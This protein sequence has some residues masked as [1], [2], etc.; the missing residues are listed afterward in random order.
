M[1]DLV[2]Q[3]CFNEGKSIIRFFKD[4]TDKLFRD[5]LKHCERKDIKR[6]SLQDTVVY[7]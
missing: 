4:F 3:D 6:E 2:E 7:L 1:E 5:S